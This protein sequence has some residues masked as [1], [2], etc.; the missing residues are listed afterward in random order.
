MSFKNFQNIHQ[1]LKETVD[2]HGEKSAYRWFNDA[3]QMES[4]SWNTFYRDVKNVSKSLLAL[5]IEKNQKVNILSYT[6]L[7]WLMVDFGIVSTGAVTVGIY[8]SNL[9]KDCQ[10]IID[11]SDAVLI[12]V[13]NEEQLE[14]ILS[15]RND[16]PNIRNVVMFNGS[17]PDDWVLSFEQFIALGKDVPDSDFEQRANEV[18]P[19]DMAGI[20]YTSGTT[21]VPKG[22]MLSHDNITFTVESV[23]QSTVIQEGEGGFLFLPL[24]HVFARITVYAAMA[25]SAPITFTRS[26]ETIVDDIKASQPIWFPSVPRIYEKVYAKVIGGAEAKGGLALKIFRWAVAVGNQVSDFKL[27][28]KPVP[29]LLNQK[30]KLATKLVFSKIQAALGGQIKWCISGAAPISPDIAKFFH[31]AGILILE[32]I[33]MTENTSFTNVNRFDNYRFGW[34]G[35]AGPGIELKIADDGELLTRGRNTMMGYYKMPEETAATISEDGW[36]HTGDIGEIDEEGFLRITGRKKDLIITA[37]GKN[38]APAAIENVL[39][40]CKYINQ[41]CVIGDKRKFL[42]A[43]VTV[44]PDVVKEYAAANGIEFNDLEDLIEHEQITQTVQTQIETLNTNFA[45]YESIKKIT[46]VPEFTIENGLLTPTMKLKKNIIIKRYQ[47]EIE[48][49]YPNS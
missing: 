42:S 35:Q 16:I 37:G 40:T 34:V 13:E 1:M 17:H 9:P 25:A 33:G 2:H 20:V 29:A 5:G 8:Q 3:G 18:Q 31:A 41:V 23:L 12:F 27:A 45:S 11:H 4:N 21:G 10:Y 19:A 7:Q 14:K 48:A 30:Y 28:K 44:D 39:A 32:G 38:I 47:T 6:C 46:I 15:I 43:L 49:M 24:A 22:V 36:L 26:M